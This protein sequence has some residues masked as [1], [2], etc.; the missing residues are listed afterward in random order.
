M[1]PFF[2]VYILRS[3]L[4]FKFYYKRDEIDDRDFL[5]HISL[6]ILWTYKYVLHLL[7]QK[8]INYNKLLESYDK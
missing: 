7:L 2:L 5:S 8:N 6:S 4:V 1:N 3:R